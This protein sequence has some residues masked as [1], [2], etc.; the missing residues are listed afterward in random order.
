[1]ENRQ[2]NRLFMVVSY[3][4]PDDRRRLKVARLL[5]DYGAQRVQRS[6]FECFITPRHGEQ[7]RARLEKQCDPDED[8]L[9]L[10]TLCENCRPRILLIGQAQPPDE[11]GLLII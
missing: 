6:V 3:D 8:S 4:I 5:L 1:M 7:L 2:R 11:P 10:Y 9:R